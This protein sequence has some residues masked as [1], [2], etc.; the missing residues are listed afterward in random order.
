MML[1]YD[2]HGETWGNRNCDIARGDAR[3]ENGRFLM[4]IAYV[5]EN[6]DTLQFMCWKPTDPGSDL[7]YKTTFATRPIVGTG[8]ITIDVKVPDWCDSQI[9]LLACNE[10][11]SVYWP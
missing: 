10:R 5:F 4:D 3:V 6:P 1:S 8:S 7:G 9:Y 2:A 11:K